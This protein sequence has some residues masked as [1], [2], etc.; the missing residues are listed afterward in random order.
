MSTTTYPDVTPTDTIAAIW[1]P[2]VLA[3]VRIVIALLFMEH[4]LQKLF[5]FPLRRRSPTRP[6][7]ACSG[8]PRSSRRSADC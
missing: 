1:A 3:V 8:S 2:R 7:S 5:S 6:R 4:G